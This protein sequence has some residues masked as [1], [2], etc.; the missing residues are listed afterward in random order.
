[1]YFPKNIYYIF[2]G[3]GMCACVINIKEMATCLLTLKWKNSSKKDRSEQRE[4]I[5]K[6]ILL[7]VASASAQLH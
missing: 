3:E 1:M 2:F 4:N 7:K 5:S 6:S